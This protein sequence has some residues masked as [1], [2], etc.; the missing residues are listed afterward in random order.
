MVES[1]F[2]GFV[3][4]ISPTNLLFCFFGVTMGTIIGVLPGVGPVAGTAMLI[5]FTFGMNAT[6]AIIML[7]GIYYGAMY[8]GS[9]TSILVNL[10]GESASV[11]TCLDGYQ[12]GRKGRAGA[13][14]GIS[15]IGSFIAGTLSVIGLMVMA[16][17]LASF[18]IRFGPP[19]YF[20]LMALGMTL[21]I[22]LVGESLV[23]G[24]IA[25]AFGIF[26]GTIGMDPTT[27]IERFSYG[28]PTLLDG[29]SFVSVSVGL[30]AISEVFEMAEQSSQAP[31]YIDKISNLLPNREDWKRSIFPDPPGKRDRVFCQRHARGG[32]HGRFHAGLCHREENIQASGKIRNRGHRRGGRTGERQQRRHRRSHDPAARSRRSGVGHVPR[33]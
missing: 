33:S 20:A 18:A 29:L 16:P 10:P 26:L 17:P 31:S 30:F 15:A 19:E 2:G 22:S 12:M 25:G 24:L 23:K 27:G 6:T 8:G 11:M 14:L 4:A 3:T 13:A 5:P 9:T 21:V 7:A 28:I 32:G 1:L